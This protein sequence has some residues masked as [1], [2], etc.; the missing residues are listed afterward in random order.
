MD[1][2]IKKELT[3]NW[4]KLLQ[5]VICNDIIALEGNRKKF[6]SN[7]WKKNLHKDE[8]GGEH[9]ILKDGKIFEYIIIVIFFNK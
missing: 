7:N 6:L 5:D 1:L 2:D 3:S 8:G 4:F 9:R